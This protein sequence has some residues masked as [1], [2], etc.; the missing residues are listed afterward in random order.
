MHNIYVYDDLTAYYQLLTTFVV[1]VRVCVRCADVV[2]YEDP[3]GRRL[4]V[5]AS[6]INYYLLL[7]LL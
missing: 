6:T 1:C 7:F 3:P 5:A 4:R 2:N